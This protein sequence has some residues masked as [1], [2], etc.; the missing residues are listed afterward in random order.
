MNMCTWAHRFL[1][2]LTP[3]CE[4]GRALTAVRGKV[5][6]VLRAAVQ[7]VQAAIQQAA[8]G[9]AGAAN[10]SSNGTQSPAPAGSG[11]GQV[12]QLA[13]GAEVPM[14]YVRFRAAAEPNLKGESTRREQCRS[15]CAV[16]ASY[17]LR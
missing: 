16:R 9:N 15:G 2:H 14:L 5:Q 8:A 6:Q 1:P 7:Q 10:G 13:E 4:Q 17:H 12:P 3:S 11:S